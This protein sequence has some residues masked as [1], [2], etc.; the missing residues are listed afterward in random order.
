[1]CFA[2][3]NKCIQCFF[4]NTLDFVKKVAIIVK[5]IEHLGIFQE[6]KKNIPDFLFFTSDFYTLQLQF[7][8]AIE[9][10]TYKSVR[11]DEKNVP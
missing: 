11:K 8:S 4:E 3:K 6:Q 2:Q 7:G 10:V 1:M 5:H 9:G